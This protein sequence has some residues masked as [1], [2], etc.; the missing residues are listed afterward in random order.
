[1]K[2]SDQAALRGFDKLPDSANVSISVVAALNSISPVTV[3][4]WSK[5]G[6]LPAP[7]KIGGAAR[8]NVGQLRVKRAAQ[9]AAAS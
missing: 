5:S 1:M 8:W 7:L 2:P 4:R 6:T 3:W 9:M